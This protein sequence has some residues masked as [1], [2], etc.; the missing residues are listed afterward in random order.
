[1]GKDASL[2]PVHPGEILKEEF[3]NPLE[4]SQNKLAREIRVSPRRISEIINAKRGITAD[5]AMRLGRFFG[6]SAKFWINLQA[7]YDLEVAEHEKAED[8]EQDVR[9]YSYAT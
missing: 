9:P 6:N 7:A 4:L 3:L 2:P 8:I 5:T 1:M